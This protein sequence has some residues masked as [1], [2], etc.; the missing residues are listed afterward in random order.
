MP[1]FAV[2]VTR[3]M[4]KGTVLPSSVVVWLIASGAGG[5]AGL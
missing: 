5:L 4:M 3:W 2:P 1:R